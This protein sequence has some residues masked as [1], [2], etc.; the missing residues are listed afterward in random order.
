M[1]AEGTV[2]APTC[3][4]IN[5]LTYLIDVH[6]VIVEHPEKR[7]Q[8]LY[9]IAVLLEQ[10]LVLLDLVGGITALLLF[11]RPKFLDLSLKL[12][13]LQV[14]RVEA[15]VQPF[16]RLVTLL[17]GRIQLRAG[18]QALLGKGFRL[19]LA[20]NVLEPLHKLERRKGACSLMRR[21]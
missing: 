21:I 1:M 20:L 10:R 16:R 11:P 15:P 14:E 7:L 19:G 13:D 8:L 9:V 3:Y 4:L 2:G 17:L 5:H 12:V 6:V 18:G